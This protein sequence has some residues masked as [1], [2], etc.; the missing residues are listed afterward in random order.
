MYQPNHPKSFD[1]ILLFTNVL[2]DTIIVIVVRRN[3]KRN[4]LTQK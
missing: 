2:I 3:I 4:L 1:F